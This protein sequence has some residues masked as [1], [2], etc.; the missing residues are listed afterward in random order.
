MTL[1]GKKLFVILWRRSAHYT[2]DE[3]STMLSV[4][5]KRCHHISSQLNKL[6][7]NLLHILIEL[8]LLSSH[9]PYYERSMCP[10]VPSYVPLYPL[11]ACL[12]PHYVPYYMV[13]PTM[14]SFI[15]PTFFSLI[16][17]RHP[18][19]LSYVPHVPSYVLIG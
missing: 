6:L 5:T 14:P 19:K 12:C 13:P 4:H 11:N 10:H 18:P 15:G 3:W 2:H 8:A 9:V 7:L 1:K 17:P 16:F